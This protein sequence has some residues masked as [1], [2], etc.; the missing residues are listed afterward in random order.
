M[1]NL[2]ELI[3]K[4]LENINESFKLKT[5]LIFTSS[6]YYN[7]DTHTLI[8][9][10]KASILIKDWN[11]GGHNNVTIDVDTTFNITFEQFIFDNSI[12]YHHLSTLKPG[13]DLDFH[14]DIAWYLDSIIDKVKEYSEFVQPG[15]FIKYSIEIYQ[16]INTHIESSEND[17]LKNYQDKIIEK[18]KVLFENKF[19]T[20]LH[21]EHLIELDLTLDFNLKIGKLAALM[22]LIEQAGYLNTS[23]RKKNAEF[24]SRY[25]RIL[26]SK[27]DKAYKNIIQDDLLGAWQKQFQ[28]ANNF[29]ASLEI[30][31]ELKNAYEVMIKRSL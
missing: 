16:I 7:S 8:N 22:A 28:D 15:N 14:E 29:K 30:L 11:Y 26:G 12:Y 3:S 23:D 5:E 9:Q 31:N 4:I 2:E 19:Q 21:G 1:G 25:S 27:K 24:L 20:N 6:P 13:L 17:V 18:F 10:E